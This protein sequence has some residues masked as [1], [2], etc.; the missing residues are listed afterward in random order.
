MK[1]QTSHLMAGFVFTNEMFSNSNPKRKTGRTPDG[2]L[3]KFCQTSSKLIT[4]NQ[5]FSEFIA[6]KG[7]IFLETKK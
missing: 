5:S 1:G 6:G 7:Y 3:K 2:C 4:F